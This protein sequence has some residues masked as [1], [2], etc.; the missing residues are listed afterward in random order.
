MVTQ[1]DFI[2]LP[3]TDDI[4]RI[5]QWLAERRLI[6]E[7]PR[8]AP[9]A[10]GRYDESHIPI[11][12]KGIIGELA[13][14]DYFHNILVN[15]YGNLPPDQRWAQVRDRLCLQNH[16]GCFDKGS[17]ITIGDRA[18]DV[19]VYADRELATGQMLNYNLF[20]NVHEVQGKTPADFYIQA[21]F[22][23]TNTIVL[24]G[25]HAGLPPDVRSDIPTPAYACP[26]RQL[27][28]VLE[29]TDILLA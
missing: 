26:V 9:G 3:I 17:D 10:F 2:E 20:V 21:F 5:S 19:K 25:Y 28:P 8:H 4:S 22:T 16:V 11:I 12:R 23:P 27:S 13:T 7:Y 6:Y 15:Q 24:A 1:A 18:I 14:F 29:L